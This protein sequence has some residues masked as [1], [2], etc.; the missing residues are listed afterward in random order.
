MIDFRALYHLA[1]KPKYLAPDYDRAVRDGINVAAQYFPVA[2]LDLDYE[3]TVKSVMEPDPDRV[4]IYLDLYPAETSQLMEYLQTWIPESSPASPLDP[5]PLKPSAYEQWRYLDRFKTV[6]DAD[7][8]L[9]LVRQATIS[10]MHVEYLSQ[11]HGAVLEEL[12]GAA[13]KVIVDNKTAYTPPQNRFIS[14]LLSVSRLNAETLKALQGN[15]AAEAQ[16]EQTVRKASSGN[17]SKSIEQM[18]T[19]AQR[20]AQK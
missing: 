5:T 1:R 17:S 9:D 12:Q 4:K 2:G 15:F 3:E 20:V 14:T 19:P 13:F 10:P 18:T 8:A 7:Y 16:G 6:V 11:I